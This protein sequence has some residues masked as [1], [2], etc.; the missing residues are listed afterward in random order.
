MSFNIILKESAIPDGAPALCSFVCEQL[1]TEASIYIS[2]DIHYSGFIKHKGEYAVMADLLFSVEEHIARI[3][4]NRPEFLNAFSEEM[5]C[6]W[7]QALEQV[8]DDDDICAAVVSGSG[9]AFCAGGDVKVMAQ[10]GGFFATSRDMTSTA[11]CRREA[12]NRIV[13]RIPLLLEEIDKPVIAK[14]HGACT[15][16]GMDMAL[17][18]DIVIAGKSAKFCESY[19]NVGLIP[20]DGGVYYLTRK[21]GRQKA[22]DLIWT[23]RFLSGEEAQ[24][25]GLTA[26]CVADEELDTFTDSYLKNLADGPQAAIRLTKRAA[27]MSERGSLADTLDYLASGMGIVSELDNYKEQ[28]QALAQRISSRQK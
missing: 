26:Y 28:V 23:R 17:M 7:A 11:Y 24:Q 5:L 3:T 22:L 4:L 12:I 14:V 9:S 15:G 27:R 8:R 25:M 21:L 19:L 13:H 1:F 20:G 10:G 2:A 16:A 18:C 6:L